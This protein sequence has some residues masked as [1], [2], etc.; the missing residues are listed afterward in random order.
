[1]LP[2]H[3]IDSNASHDSSRPAQ[4]FPTDTTV[5]AGWTSDDEDPVAVT[6]EILK[7]MTISKVSKTASFSDLPEEIIEMILQ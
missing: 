2:D 5:K 3:G 6:T 7:G 1:M 4:D